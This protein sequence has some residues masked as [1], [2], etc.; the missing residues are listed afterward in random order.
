M[1]TLFQSLAQQAGPALA[2]AF[3]TLAALGGWLAKESSANRKVRRRWRE[4]LQAPG[5]ASLEETLETHLEERRRILSELRALQDRVRVLE[6]KMRV[7]KRHLGIVRYDAFDDVG[8]E[9]SF[10][11]ALYD[12][13]G[14]GVVLTSLVGRTDC[15][16]YAKAL[17]KGRSDRTLSQEE[18]RAIREAEPHDF[19]KPGADVA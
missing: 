14:D 1:E 6:D 8:G 15:R 9:Q 10:A 17:R 5:G 3:A 18:Q 19:S 2:I 12:D 16:V 7:D 4:L 11:L 13:E